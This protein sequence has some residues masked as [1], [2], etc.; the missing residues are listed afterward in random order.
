M[1]YSGIKQYDIANGVGIRTSL[2][3]S[4]CNFHCKGCFN[5][6]SQSFTYGKPF[7][8]ETMFTII[9]YLES[10]RVAGLSLLGGD[11]LWQDAKGLTQLIALCKETH[12]LNK[13]IW[14]WSGFTWEE[15]M[16]DSIR[17]TLNTFRK[18]LI[19]NC[20]VWVD[21]QFELSKRDLRLQWCGSTNQRVIDVKKSLK[22][23]QIV[24]YDKEM[25]I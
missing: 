3:V 19:S 11:P 13:S 2:F 23:N 21:G 4:G 15:I 24:L 9:N 20:N 18:E 5:Q 16:G 14:I 10:D 12:M 17:D 25:L 1:N 6:E 7:T 8:A 22:E